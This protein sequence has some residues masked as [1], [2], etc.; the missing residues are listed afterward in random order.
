MSD[1]IRDRLRGP[2]S[3]VWAVVCLG[4]TLG[5]AAPL[6]AQAP[7]SPIQALDLYRL[8]QPVDPQVSPDGRT[9]AVLRQTRDINTDRVNHELWLVSVADGTR[10]MLVGADRSPGGVRW[11][12]DGTRLAFI[13]REGGKQG[14]LSYLD[15]G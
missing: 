11:S 14:L 1:T 4:V 15:I 3:R 7:R 10:R 6:W 13:G 9:I 12:P 5:L 8:E 2:A